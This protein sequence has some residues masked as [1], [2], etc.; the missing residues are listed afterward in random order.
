M[1]HM[2]LKFLKDCLYVNMG[3]WQFFT[4]YLPIDCIHQTP[5]VVKKPFWHSSLLPSLEFTSINNSSWIK[6]TEWNTTVMTEKSNYSC[7]SAEEEKVADHKKAELSILQSTVAHI[8]MACFTWT[9]FSVSPCPLSLCI[10]F[11]WWESKDDIDLR[12]CP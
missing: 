8:R 9:V 1:L 3:A 4:V 7:C 2:F 6:T 11:Y 5:I 10:Y 12:L